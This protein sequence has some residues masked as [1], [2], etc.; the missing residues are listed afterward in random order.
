[1]GVVSL[2]LASCCSY[3]KMDT[4]QHPFRNIEVPHFQ[5]GAAPRGP[6]GTATGQRRRNRAPGDSGNSGSS[7]AAVQAGGRRS[8]P[9]E[10]WASAT[11][12]FPELTELL[13]ARFC[14][15]WPAGVIM[16]GRACPAHPWKGPPALPGGSQLYGQLYGQSTG[17]LWAITGNRMAIY[18]QRFTAVG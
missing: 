14:R 12:D 6:P 4:V 15:R 18:G 9:P 16:A 11:R 2:A 1:M 8:R 5:R 17:N 3:G 7:R 13:G 10:P